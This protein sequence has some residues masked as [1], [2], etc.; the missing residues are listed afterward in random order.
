V[1]L[2]ELELDMTWSNR[3][4]DPTASGLVAA[5]LRLSPA[6]DHAR[7]SGTFSVSCMTCRQEILDRMDRI[8]R[9]VRNQ[10]LPQHPVDPVHPVRMNSSRPNTSVVRDPAQGFGVYRGLA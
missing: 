1:S 6:V 3:C 4:V 5:R 9:M 2:R 8:H 7:R 10:S